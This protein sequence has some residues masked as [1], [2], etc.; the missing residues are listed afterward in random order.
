MVVGPKAASREEHFTISPREVLRFARGEPAEALPLEEWVWQKRCWER[1]RQKAFFC[2]YCLA[3]YFFFWW[4]VGGG[5]RRWAA[6]G[7]VFHVGRAVAASMV[8]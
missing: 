4:K 3:K 5:R 8:H 2:K 6:C 1:L 7:G